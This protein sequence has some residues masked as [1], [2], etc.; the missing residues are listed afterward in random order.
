M[1]A[2]LALLTAP[3]HSLTDSELM[4]QIWP[5]VI[6][7]DASL[8]QVIAQLRKVLG[9]QQKP[10]QWIERVQR[11]G[12]RLCQPA[13]AV[14]AT[15]TIAILPTEQPLPADMQAEH[16]NEPAT[17][18]QHRS[19]LRQAAGGQPLVIV[20]PLTVVVLLAAVVLLMV[21][22]RYFTDPAT[23]PALFG[24]ALPSPAPASP[25][26]ANPAL[27]NFALGNPSA[28]AQPIANHELSQS[29]TAVNSSSA[30]LT[31]PA[32]FSAAHWA[33]WQQ[34]VYLL[35]QP[36]RADINRARLLLE[37]LL[38]GHQQFTAL[39]VALCDSYHAMYHYDDWPLQRVLAQCDP[40]LQQA[41]RQ[42][43]D[44]APA[45]SSFGALRLSHGDLAG[46]AFYLAKAYQ[47]EPSAAETLH[48]QALLARAKADFPL[49]VQYSAKA[50]AQ[51]PLSGFMARQHAY[52]LIANGQLTAARA[53][54]IQALLLDSDYSDR[55]LD[56]LE[57]LPLTGQRAI[58][59]LR[60]A[61]QY[62]D[63]LK[64]QPE[65]AIHLALVYLSLGQPATASQLLQQLP[66]GTQS[67]SFALLARAML[68]QASGDSSQ[69]ARLLQQRATLASG[70]R[71]W[72][73]QALVLNRANFASANARQQS[74][75]QLYQWL[76]AYQTDAAS[77]L[78]RDL[79]D[80][81]QLHAMF[82]LLC[83]PE[84]MRHRHSA[85]IRQ[86]VQAQPAPD[87]FSLKLLLLT[88]NTAKAA[89]L[90]E[91][92][93]AADW[94]PGVHD[95]YFLPADDPSYANLPKAVYQQ[96]LQ[97]PAQVWA[98]ALQADVRTA[99]APQQ[100]MGTAVR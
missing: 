81:Q 93:L 64:Q 75:Q 11:K 73:L 83:L 33:Q 44:F 96:L 48:R 58:A 61:K 37:Q 40:L 72:Q 1:T 7:S 22:G 55:A 51:R 69:A 6:V 14:T 92:L 99:A 38:N 100:L 63:R 42:N 35:Q 9:D 4:Q 25:A 62:P 74:L 3:E 10:Y 15:Q 80:N 89:E 91:Q 41:L 20:V 94:L 70:H 2:L 23:A 32:S 78:V 29:A 53:Q 26:V 66:A 21:S 59:A 67:S 5:Q 28:A 88:G 17:P 30:Q 31:A 45:L 27:D 56:E 77:A 85:A 16:H 71:I 57:L 24:P 12:Y 49:A 46:A 13:V 86:Y 50:V 76:P 60:W 8:Y 95:D 52:N 97:H 54:F 65:R 47:L 84:Q 36:R 98:Q 19:R 79:R 82:Y 87:S 43:A 18:Q 34:A 39:L 90:A 68:A